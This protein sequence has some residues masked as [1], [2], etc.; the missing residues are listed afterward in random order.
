MHRPAAASA[1]DPQAMGASEPV[2]GL[3][4]LN[5]NRHSSS[6][7]TTESC[8]SASSN[9]TLVVNLNV[10]RKRDTYCK[11]FSIRPSTNVVTSHTASAYNR[12]IGS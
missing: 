1:F 8:Q 3:S 2:I 11:D 12:A 4:R 9:L 7:P 10:L 5:H 6:S